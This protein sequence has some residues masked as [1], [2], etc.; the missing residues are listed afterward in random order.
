MH[1]LQVKS[2]SLSIKTLHLKDLTEKEVKDSRM[3]A[4]KHGAFQNKTCSNCGGY[5]H[6]FRQCLAP[7]TSH[8]VIVFRVSNNW[9]P[10]RTL[11]EN[12]SAITGLR[13]LEQFNFFSSNERIV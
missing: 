7:V 9:N 11:A 12:E 6:S 8:G 3:R 13:G 5:N 2:I 1:L 4:N 10:A